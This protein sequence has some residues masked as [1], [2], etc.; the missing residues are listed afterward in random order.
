MLVV[1]FGCDTQHLSILGQA[2]RSPEHLQQWHPYSTSITLVG[3]VAT[4]LGC[5][6]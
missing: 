4:H 1:L 2:Y 5:R 6:R 3:N